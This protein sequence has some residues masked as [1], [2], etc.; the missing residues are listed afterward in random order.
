MIKA[1]T[2]ILLFLSLSIPAFNLGAR[3]Y[4]HGHELKVYSVDIVDTEPEF[5]G[6]SRAM[7]HFINETRR[8][9]KD[10]EVRQGR[11]ICGFVILP[12][13]RITC[14]SILKGLCNDLDQEALR[15]I[16]EMPRWNAGRINGVPVAVYYVLPIGFR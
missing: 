5:P 9:P 10:A 1:L 2:P 12:D 4:S 15:I 11:V 6:G 13:G 3:D 8:T 16:N 7:L 14:A